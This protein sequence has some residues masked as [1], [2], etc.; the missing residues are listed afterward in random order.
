MG[1][2]LSMEGTDLAKETAKH[3]YQHSDLFRALGS[4]AFKVRAGMLGIGSIVKSSGYEFV[5]DEDE[6]SESVVVHIVLPRKE[7]EALGEAAAKDLGIDTKSMS[8]IELPEWKGVFI[9]DLKV[10]LEKW[11]EI[12]CLKGPGDNLTF[13]RAAYKKESRPWR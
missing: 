12:K 4:A 5:V 7:I 11:H 3:V 10:L 1:F 13:E 9:D 2:V 6:L 8:D